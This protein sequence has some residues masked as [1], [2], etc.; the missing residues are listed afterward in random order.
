MRRLAK[1]VFEVVGDEA[2]PLET[3]PSTGVEDKLL[4]EQSLMTL[5]ATG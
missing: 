5:N 3:V 2:R 4:P 1:E